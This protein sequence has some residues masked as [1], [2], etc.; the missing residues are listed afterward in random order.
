MAEDLFVSAARR[1]GAAGREACDAIEAAVDAFELLIQSR[2][3]GASLVDI[4]DDL[5]GR[6]AR[7]MRLASIDAFREYERAV[8]A[9]RA[10]LVRVLVDE[11][12]LSL[13]DVAGR[14]MVS[15]QAVARLYRQGREGLE[16]PSDQ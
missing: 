4:A 2:L 9:M 3:A 14:L 7:A 15:R 11:Y 8:G 1:V 10:S 5:I 13:T 6:G 12:G 16:G